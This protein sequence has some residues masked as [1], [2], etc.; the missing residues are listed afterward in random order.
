MLCSPKVIHQHVIAI[1]RKIG[2]PTEAV[3]VDVVP[4]HDADFNECFFNVSN[5][6]K[7]K[8]GSIQHGWC[9]WENPGLFIEGE[10][11]GVWKT[12]TGELIDVTPKKDGEAKIL[13]LPD[14]IRVF[15]EDTY[16]R[17]DNIRL[18]VSPHPSVQAFLD[19]AAELQKYK[20]ECSDPLNPKLMRIDTY[21]LKCYETNMA[22]AEMA[23]M[24]L[25]I[26]RNDPCRCGS[27]VKFKKCCG[28]Q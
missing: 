6:I 18:A 16:N 17:L 8:G 2:C 3:W 7:R 15:D 19:S 22:K 10:F 11:H 4:E 25:P 23:M 26:G 27:G 14:P 5:T 1:C 28:K 21:K 20:E 12:P 9:I 13:F 24:H